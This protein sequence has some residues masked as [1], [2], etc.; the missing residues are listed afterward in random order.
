MA[1]GMTPMTKEWIEADASMC[2]PMT[3]ILREA[4]LLITP[5][6]C[7]FPELR[8]ETYSVKMGIPQGAK[9]LWWGLGGKRVE[10]FV[11]ST[12]EA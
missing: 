10:P 2:S 7:K 11:L 12:V 9:P 4:L 6:W 3:P 8:N 1:P 5:D